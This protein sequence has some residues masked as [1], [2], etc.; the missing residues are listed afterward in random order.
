MNIFSL[1]RIHYEIAAPAEISVIA[2]LDDKYGNL[3]KL[4]SSRGYQWVLVQEGKYSSEEMIDK[5]LFWS[6]IYLLVSRISF[7]LFIFVIAVVYVEIPSSECAILTLMTVAGVYAAI[8]LVLYGFTLLVGVVIGV[9][10][11]SG[12]I[13]SKSVVITTKT[14]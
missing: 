3:E 14:V 6:R 4:R 5:D 13:L 12:Y 8:W 1:F 11:A 9:V 2:R 10:A 7:S